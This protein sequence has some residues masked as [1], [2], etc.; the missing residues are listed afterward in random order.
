MVG[1]K[2]SQILDQAIVAL[3]DSKDENKELREMIRTMAE[4]HKALVIRS[5]AMEE[6]IE[7]LILSQ[8]QVSTQATTTFPASNDG[9]PSNTQE[10]GKRSTSQEVNHAVTNIQSL[11]ELVKPERAAVINAQ[12]DKKEDQ[13]VPAP[14]LVLK[15][16]KSA[17]TAALKVKEQDK[18]TATETLEDDQRDSGDLKKRPRKKKLE[19]IPEGKKRQYMVMLKL[20]RR[21]YNHKR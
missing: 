8:Q 14:A 5:Q 1:G 18:E 17:V 9:E 20:L 19:D 16:D 4:S 7:G 6:K 13:S 15:V 2:T 3:K 21:C 12:E 11:Q 10:A